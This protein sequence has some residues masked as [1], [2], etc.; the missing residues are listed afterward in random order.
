MENAISGFRYC[1]IVL[2]NREILPHSEFLQKP[3]DA[4]QVSKCLREEA[5]ITEQPSKLEEPSA[6]KEAAMPQGT[7]TATE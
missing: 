4:V 3:V 7:A 5:A 1:G 2:F 6:P